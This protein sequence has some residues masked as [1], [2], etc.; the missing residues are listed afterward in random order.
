MHG[1][2][3]FKAFLHSKF[4]INI[5]MKSLFVGYDISETSLTPTTKKP[6]IFASYNQVNCSCDDQLLLEYCT[7]GPAL[8]DSNMME[9]TSPIV[10]DTGANITCKDKYS[11][12]SDFTQFHIS[13]ELAA[14]SGSA[15][16]D[17]DTLPECI[18]ES[19]YKIVPNK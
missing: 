5:Y 6:I 18:C 13:C 15:E 14:E 17:L 4:Y 11:F 7:D 8:P 1:I 9:V 16:W 10:G 12:L 19:Q 3:P 2:L